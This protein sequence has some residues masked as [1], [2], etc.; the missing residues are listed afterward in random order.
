MNEQ[1]LDLQLG[2]N[3]ILEDH[4][5]CPDCGGQLITN[6]GPGISCTFCTSCN[7]SDYDYDMG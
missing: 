5:E 6:Y 3:E 7:Y 1:N 2:E 4:I